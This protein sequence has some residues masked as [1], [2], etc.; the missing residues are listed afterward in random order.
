MLSSC[1]CSISFYVL[2]DTCCHAGSTIASGPN[3]SE[4][5]IR[6]LSVPGFGNHMLTDLHVLAVICGN[7][8]HDYARHL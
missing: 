8:D 5:P 6:I 3:T 1:T 7:V 2:P 4:F